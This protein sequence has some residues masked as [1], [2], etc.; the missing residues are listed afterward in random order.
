MPTTTQRHKVT[1]DSSGET[2]AAWHYPGRNGGCVVM[3]AGLAVIKEAG[4]DQIASVLNSAG[5][6]VL[7]F[8]YRRLGESSGTPRQL[9]RFR[10]QVADFQ[11]AVEFA[12]ALPEVDSR[13]LVVWGFSISGGHVFTVAAR[14][15]QLAAAIAHAPAADGWQLMPNA[16]RHTTVLGFLRLIGRAILDT[17]GEA[18]GRAPLLVPLAGERGAVAALTT[19]D[20]RNYVRALN[21]D[22]RY[23]QWTQAVAARSAVGAG[24]YRPARYAA[25]IACPLLVLAYDDD[26]VAPAGQAVRA[27]RRAPN[28]RVVHLP[29]GH[30]AAFLDATEQTHRTLLAFL[31]R[32]LGG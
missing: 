29:G 6:S 24:L 23:P 30:Y 27:A 12:A 25:K 13:K 15:P 21:P 20:S 28:G 4:T 19:P 9:I 10:D 1:F 14:N 11:A 2:C 18:L 22:N 3:A 16:L 5:Y 7:A 26:G 32:E 8:D 31:D 17:V